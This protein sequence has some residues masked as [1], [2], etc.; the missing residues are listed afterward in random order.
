M[1]SAAPGNCT[2]QSV[3]TCSLTRITWSLDHLQSA[4][5]YPWHCSSLCRLTAVQRAS[6]GSL[7]KLL[8]ALAASAPVWYIGQHI[9]VR[10]RVHETECLTS[11]WLH[12]NTWE[13]FPYSVASLH[14][15]TWNRDCNR[16]FQTSSMPLWIICPVGIQIPRGTVLHSRYCRLTSYPPFLSGVWLPSSGLFLGFY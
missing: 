1:A 13:T 2:T 3:Q 9:V 10:R 8:T 15:T 7:L 16:P 14:R 11:F 12:P 5:E 6:R 4:S